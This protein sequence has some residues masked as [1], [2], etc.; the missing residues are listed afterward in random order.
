MLCVLLAIVASPDPLSS[1]LRGHVESSLNG[2]IERV[3]ERAARNQLSTLDQIVLRSGALTGITLGTFKYP[4]AS[5]IL[6]HYLYGSGEPLALPAQYIRS[7]PHVRDMIATLGLGTHGPIAFVQSED[8]ELSLALNPYYLEISNNRVRV[9]HPR[10]E[11]AGT[12]AAPVPTVVPIGRLRIR[13]FDNL[14]TALGGT[15]FPVST[16]WDLAKDRTVPSG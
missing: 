9:F 8:W 12:S 5:K 11:F 2:W 1:F 14:V 16:H 7:S 13:V 10:V 15:P 4:D 6:F 3:A